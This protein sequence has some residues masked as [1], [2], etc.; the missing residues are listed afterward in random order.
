M[1]MSRMATSEY[2]GAKRRAY[3]NAKPGKRRRLL[4]EVCETTGYSRKYANRLLT[5]SRK[6]K[7]RKG[8]GPTY[9]EQDKAALVRIWREVGCPCTTYFRANIDEWLR[10]FRAC[11]AHVPDDVAA[12]VLSMSASTMDRLLK[13]VKREKPG[14][15]QRNRRSGRNDELLKARIGIND[16]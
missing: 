10:E 8:R 3:A 16:I 5:G 7:E 12:H 11:V 2:I 1:N 14:S 4:D 9:T 15:M 13:G 6:F